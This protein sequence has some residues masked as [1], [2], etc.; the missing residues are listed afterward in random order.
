MMDTNKNG[1]IS[2]EE[3]KAGL[4]KLGSQLGENEIH[5]LMDAVSDYFLLFF[6]HQSETDEICVMIVCSLIYLQ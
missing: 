4:Y 3:F 5:Q 6:I 2:F 1:F